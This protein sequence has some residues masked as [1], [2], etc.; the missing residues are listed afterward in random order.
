MIN[1]ADWEVLRDMGSGAAS[2]A[3]ANGLQSFRAATVACGRMA[4]AS[5]APYALDDLVCFLCLSG[6]KELQSRAPKLPPP[7]TPVSIEADLGVGDAVRPHQP[8]L[9]QA[10]R[11]ISRRLSRKQHVASVLPGASNTS[12]PRRWRRFTLGHYAASGAEPLSRTLPDWFDCLSGDS[13]KPC[14]AQCCRALRDACR[15]LDLKSIVPRKQH[16]ADSVASMFSLKAA[17]MASLLQNGVSESEVLRA[18]AFALHVLEKAAASGALREIAGAPISDTD[19]EH[20]RRAMAWALVRLS[21]KMEFNRESVDAA[22][23]IL[24]AQAQPLARLVAAMEARLVTLV[25][26]SEVTCALPPSP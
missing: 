21:V 12:Q 18:H 11:H 26:G 4:A 13:A 1:D 7:A 6:S 3:A 15:S 22:I 24:L 8:F 25:W 17:A 16:V 23:T 19:D 2:G 20:R 14:L 10:T 5:G 9:A